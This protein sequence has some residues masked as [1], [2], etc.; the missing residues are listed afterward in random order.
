MVNVWRVHVGCRSI[1]TGIAGCR[2]VEPLVACCWLKVWS[3]LV[4]SLLVYMIVC[5]CKTFMYS[6]TVINKNIDF[7]KDKKGGICFP[8]PCKSMAFLQIASKQSQG[9]GKLTNK[10]VCKIDQK[11][12]K[13]TL[14]GGVVDTLKWR[15][16]IL[17]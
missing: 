6:I 3:L 16:I 14:K 2:I 5:C 15:W 12:L 7:N 4:W 8:L 11:Q 17:M 13:W 1:K 9:N 10:T